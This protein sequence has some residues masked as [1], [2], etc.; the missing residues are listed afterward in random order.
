MQPFSSTTWLVKNACQ[1]SGRPINK[2]HRVDDNCP[3]IGD[4]PN[5]QKAATS[6]RA[7]L[8]ER[9]EKHGVGG[10]RRGQGQ[11]LINTNGFHW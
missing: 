2:F 8:G 3:N 10:E 4:W 5:S 7:G 11:E 9:H 6:S 1:K